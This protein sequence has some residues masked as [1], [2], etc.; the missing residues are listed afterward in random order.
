MPAEVS[1]GRSLAATLSSIHSDRPGFAAAP[2]VS[3]EAEP[4]VPAA[5]KVEVRKVMTFLASEDFTVWIALPA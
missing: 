5:S 1:S 2:M 4:P 3:T